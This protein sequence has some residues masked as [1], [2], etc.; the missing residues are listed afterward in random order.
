[1]TSVCVFVFFS[2]IYEG[3][4]PVI[5]SKGNVLHN[6]LTFIALGCSLKLFSG[7]NLVFCNKNKGNTVPVCLLLGIDN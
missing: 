5:Q 3:A 7:R 4:I 6:I 1:M 2:F